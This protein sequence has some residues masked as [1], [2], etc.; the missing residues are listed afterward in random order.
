MHRR[1]NKKEKKKENLNCVTSCE[2]PQHPAASVDDNHTTQHK[3]KTSG[4]RAISIP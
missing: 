1:S 2:I 3:L 4:V